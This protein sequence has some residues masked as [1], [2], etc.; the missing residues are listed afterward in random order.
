MKRVFTVWVILDELNKPF[1]SIY[2]TRKAAMDDKE[3][4][5]FTGCRPCKVELKLP[6]VL[7]MQP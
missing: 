3:L 5:E 7:P 1:G 4:W 6:R 2:Q